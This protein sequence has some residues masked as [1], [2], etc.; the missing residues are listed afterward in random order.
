MVKSSLVGQG[1]LLS[2]PNTFPLG[3]FER[4]FPRTKAR[5]SNPRAVAPPLISRP[6]GHRG[7]SAQAVLWSTEATVVA[8]VGIGVYSSYFISGWRPSVP[9]PAGNANNYAD[10]VGEAA[11][12]SPEVSDDATAKAAFKAKT[13]EIFKP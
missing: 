4:N 3:R 11:T 7:P 13:D 9:M 12:S 6:T 5:G 1:S 2:K 10:K 8:C